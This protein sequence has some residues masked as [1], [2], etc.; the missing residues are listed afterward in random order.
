MAVIQKLKTVQNDVIVDIVCDIC[1][2]TTRDKGDLNFEYSQLV[3][4][5]GYFSKKDDTRWNLVF[6]ETC[7]DLIMDSIGKL[8][9]RL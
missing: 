8:K 2:N 6:C 3:A 9:E 4:S 1:G 5:W 7:S